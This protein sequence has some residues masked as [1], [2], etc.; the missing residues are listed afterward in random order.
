VGG[1][2]DF[3][4]TAGVARE[5]VDEKTGNVVNK[6]PKFW[7]K[8]AKCVTGWYNVGKCGEVEVGDQLLTIRGIFKRELANT[9]S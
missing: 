6:S 5:F 4:P 8:C 2:S 9:P 3:L 1:N 7:L